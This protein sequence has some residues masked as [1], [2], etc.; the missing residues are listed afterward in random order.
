MHEP[1]PE[2]YTFEGVLDIRKYF[3]L[4]QKYGMVVI[5]RPGPFIDAEVDFVR[6]NCNDE[7]IYT[8]FS[9]HEAD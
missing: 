2:E 5:L 3:Q 1:E 4:A 8:G 7:F 6:D 9:A